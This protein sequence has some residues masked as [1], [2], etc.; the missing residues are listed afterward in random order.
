MGAFPTSAFPT[1]YN[2]CLSVQQG[3]R[4]SRVVP[5][6][7]GTSGWSYDDWVGPVYRGI[8]PADRLAWYSE[9]FPAVEVDMTYYRDP[10]PSVVEGW[11][12]KVAERKG[13][14]LSVKAPQRVTHEAMVD[15]DPADVA[16]LLDDW[17]PRVPL[18]LARAGRLG[19]VLLQLSPAISRNAP[20]LGRIA[21]AL[22]AL[23]AFPVT[24]E[25]R[26][27]SWHDEGRLTSDA[28]ALLDAR[29]AAVT[30]TD[31]PGFP[32]V[33]ANAADHAFVRFHGRNRDAWFKRV[34]RDERY[35]YDYS[36]D[37]LTPWSQRLADLARE[38]RVV[39]VFFNNHV[40]GKA[41][42]N[43]GLMEDLLEEEGAPLRRASSPQTRLP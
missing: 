15:G 28:L 4:A 8:A 16:R 9:R 21:A 23:R 3:P 40:D 38:K 6:L 33:E 36:R 7:V 35:D 1:P 14:E 32:D 10:E 42:R 20:S 26:H 37:E 5:I 43:A 13:F 12:R 30:L 11:V 22:D 39:R 2:G 24:V 27:R 17:V 34:T 25:F 29:G 19:A 31:G 18:P 41:F